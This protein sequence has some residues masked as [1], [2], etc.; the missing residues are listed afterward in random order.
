V[1][2]AGQTSQAA[3]RQETI[4]NLKHM[5]VRTRIY[6]GFGLLILIGISVTV[7]GIN[8]LTQVGRHLNELGHVSDD[9]IRGQEMALRLE[10]IGRAGFRY[11]TDGA[12]DGLQRMRGNITEASNL[13]QQSA[14]TTT[15]DVRRGIY[16]HVQT[17]LGTYRETV[18]RLVTL[19]TRIV[20]GRKA[21]SKDGATLTAA[22]DKLTQ[23][24]T[25]GG[26]GERAAKAERAFLLMRAANW[27]FQT[28][29]DP[30]AQT[31]FKASQV[32]T[33]AAIAQLDQMAGAIAND[34]IRADISPVKA[35][36]ATYAAS[37]NTVAT[38]ILGMDTLFTSEMMPG[39]AAM[40]AQIQT[41]A[42]SL[43]NS[44]TASRQA[45]QETITSATRLQEGL[46]ALTFV[47]GTSLAYV[48]GRGI[49]GPIQAMT[50][51]MTTLATGDTTVEI[52][53]R[54]SGNE[55]GDMAR[56]VAVFR[57]NMIQNNTLAA[58]RD[59]E[60]AGKEA[61]QRTIDSEIE[62]F[63][64]SVRGLLGTL[65]AA[66]FEMRAT[67]QTMSATAEQTNQQA[68]AVSVAAEQA[69]ANVQTM[70]AATEEM[71]SSAA[72][73]AR[74]VTRSTTIAAQA[75][76]A[77]RNTDRQVQGLTDA[78]QKIEAV[79]AIINGIAGQTNLLALNATIEAAR[80]GDAGKGFAVVASEVKALAA[81]TGKATDQIGAQIQAIQSATQA[82]V[83]AIKGIGTTIDEMNDISTAIAAAMEEQGATTQ[84][85]ARTTQEAARGTQDVS[86]T[87]GGVSDGARATGSA[88]SQ[89]L[90]A[91]GEL[92][93]K[94]ET[95]RS[96]VDSFLH[97]I[98]AA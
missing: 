23:T 73:I 22:I 13:L 25:D 50:A 40:Q 11:K 9:T 67:A 29:Q 16:Q 79:V 14:A 74:Q 21:L 64:G 1:P 12:A 28:N 48:I 88:A 51:T 71:A 90:S 7:L 57:T 33:E 68:S 5:N 46:T 81:Q 77:A 41:A 47:L 63:D 45:G 15:S 78:A 55:I 20:A 93:V 36:I 39:L 10:A 84:E 49:A 27:H 96:E 97:R 43:Q 8:R 35:G 83:T 58:E 3:Y 34:A 98:R 42:A 4:V 60:Q 54:D 24:A 95:L 6:A 19:Q 52:P 85:M 91:A 18:D 94:A 26:L 82:A 17:R 69:S 75:V 66:S 31:A 87:I 37:F 2:R 89:V 30:N 53:A 86:S 38:E 61:R 72:E 59:T 76:D 92:G 65:G 70:A 44:F 80:A 56:A 32:Q 62:T